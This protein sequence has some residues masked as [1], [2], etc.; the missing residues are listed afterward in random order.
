MQPHWQYF[1]AL[2][3]DL[4]KCTRFVEPHS[5]NFAVYSLEFARLLLATCSEVDVV[6]KMLCEKLDTHADRRNI[7]NYRTVITQVKPRFPEF[8]VDVPRYGLTYCP[9][10]NWS[11]GA[12][13][14]WWQ[15]HNNVKHERNTKYNEA[16]LNNCF[17]ALSGL[18]VLLLYFYSEGSATCKMRTSPSLFE[19]RWYGTMNPPTSWFIWPLLD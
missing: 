9:W 7:D 12:N 11:S 2:E 4:V 13:P 3:D 8:E 19:P 10:G 1:L 15:S 14:P 5:S 18:L 17:H 16:T 6:S